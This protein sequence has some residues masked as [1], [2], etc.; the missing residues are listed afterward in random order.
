MSLDAL[1]SELYEYRLLSYRTFSTVIGIMMKPAHVRA[2][3]PVA[4]FAVLLSFGSE[5]ECSAP[6]AAAL[7]LPAA[8]RLALCRNALRLEKY[9][10][11]PKPVR[12]VLGNVPLQN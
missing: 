5:L 9:M 10:A 2:N 11:D 3:A 6:L 1:K 7:L 8:A 12:R 4:R